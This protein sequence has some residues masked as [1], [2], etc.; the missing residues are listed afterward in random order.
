MT[1]EVILVDDHPMF[2]KGL[3]H[4][5]VDS[6]AVKVIG[7]FPDITTTREWIAQGGKADVALL[8]RTLR[9]E[10][11]LDLVPLLKQHNIKIIM[12][13]IADAD[14]EIRD[15]IEAG[16]DGYLLKTSE[17]EQ[18]LQVITGVHQGSSMFPSHVMQKMAKGELLHGIFDKL[19]QRELEIVTYV[20]RGLSNR[21]IGDSLGLSENTVRNHL[22]SILE[23][24]NLANRVQVATLALEH[25]IVKR[26]GTS[27]QEV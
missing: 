6:P 18:I 15:A 7:E 21:A 5:L 24:L 17:P 26:K 16:V 8:D 20:A 19:S 1:I 22:R 4:L 9:E 23:K 14:Y 27:N 25:G 12:L 2:R 11:G 13:T 3:M 10:D